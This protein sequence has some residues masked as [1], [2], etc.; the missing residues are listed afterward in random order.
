MARLLGVGM[1]CVTSEKNRLPVLAIDKA[2]RLPPA[3]V[4]AIRNAFRNGGLRAVECRLPSGRPAFVPVMQPADFG[5]GDDAAR[6]RELHTAWIRLIFVQREV[7]ASSM[8][9]AD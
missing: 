3:K 9:V 1:P 7:R 8:I 5:N 6:I 2:P 4:R